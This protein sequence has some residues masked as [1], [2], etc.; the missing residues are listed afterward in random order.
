MTAPTSEDRLA[1]VLVGTALG[2]ALGLPLENLSARRIERLF[3]RVTRF[4]FLGR[5]GFVSDDTEQTAFVADALIRAGPDDPDRGARAF[6]WR[7]RGW[8]LRAP[9]GVGFA[10]LRACAKLLLFFPPSKSGVRSAGNGAAMRTAI[11]GAFFAAEPPRRAAWSE[12][13]ARVTHT[14]PRAIQGAGYVA[15]LAAQAAQAPSDR[16]PDLLAAAQGVV[17]DASLLKAIQA[18]QHFA[19]VGAPTEEAAPA[20]GVTGFVLH[21]VPFAAYAYARWGADPRQALEEAVNAGGDSDTT[22][23]IV[24]ALVG[25]RHGLSGLPQDLVEHLEDGPLGRRHLL[26]LAHALA[27]GIPARPPGYSAL[28]LLARNLL[29]LPVIFGHVGWRVVGALFKR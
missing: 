23:A 9:F 11:L 15:A 1:G 25:A 14:D 8:V 29:L 24:G 22:G 17:E 7:L 6:A 2:D 19:Q 18:A 3:G 16:A 10:T 27:S 20:L 13:I 5:T 12:A 21:T 4:R 28:K 26:A